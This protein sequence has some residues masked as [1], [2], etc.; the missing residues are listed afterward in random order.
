MIHWSDVLGLVILM[1][2]LILY[3]FGHDHDE[4]SSNDNATTSQDTNTLD[5]TTETVNNEQEEEPKEGFL[6]F[7]REPFMLMGDI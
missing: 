1:A 7:L 6:E 2:G 4:E 5:P 3:R